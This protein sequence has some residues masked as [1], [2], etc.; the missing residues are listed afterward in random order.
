MSDASKIETV[1]QFRTRLARVLVNAG[2]E[3]ELRASRVAGWLSGM[4]MSVENL[5]DNGNDVTV[6]PYPEPA[7]T[8]DVPGARSAGLKRADLTPDAL[9]KRDAKALHDA[10]SSAYDQIKHQIRY[11]YMSDEIGIKCLTELGLPVPSKA[12][13]VSAHIAGIGDVQFQHA[14]EITRAQVVEA[15]TPFATD[16]RVD[17]IMAAFPGA[18]GVRPGV[19]SVYI[20]TELSW[21]MF[22]SFEG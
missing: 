15:F 12:S 17:A 2:K 10:K 9:A 14:G 5:T 3:M 18:Q 13:T 8:D 20:D 19:T 1:A 16:L 6:T 21:P 11:G 22:P 7:D 4:G